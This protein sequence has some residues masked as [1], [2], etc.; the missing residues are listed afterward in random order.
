MVFFFVGKRLYLNILRNNNFCVFVL[1][2]G[3]LIVYE[4]VFEFFRRTSMSALFRLEK[5]KTSYIAR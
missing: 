4:Y 1:V 5:I 2:D 3:L